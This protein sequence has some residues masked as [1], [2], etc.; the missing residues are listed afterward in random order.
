MLLRGFPLEQGYYNSVK[1]LGFEIIWRRKVQPVIAESAPAGSVLIPVQA[2]RTAAFM[3]PVSCKLELW[4][5]D[6][7][8]IN[9]TGRWQYLAKNET[10]FHSVKVQQLRNVVLLA[11]AFQRLVYEALSLPLLI[12]QCA[13][14]CNFLPFFLNSFFGSIILQC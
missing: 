11:S 1:R 5:Q 2:S 14:Q 12:S 3:L 6:T 13:V 9:P 4:Y 8:F 7:R 10:A